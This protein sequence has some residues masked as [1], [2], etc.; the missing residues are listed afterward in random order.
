MGAPNLVADYSDSE[1]RRIAFVEPDANEREGHLPNAVY[2]CGARLHRRQL[3]IPFG[4]E[5]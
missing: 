3:V 1:I 5:E 2:S 4:D